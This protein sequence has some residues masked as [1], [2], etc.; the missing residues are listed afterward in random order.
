MVAPISRN[1]PILIAGA[2]GFIGGWLVRHLHEQGYTNLRAIDIKPLDDW[3]QV[4]PGVASSAA[5]L[6]SLEACEA[7]SLIHI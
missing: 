3:Y 1:D 5:D 4:L 6:R 2:G 7:L